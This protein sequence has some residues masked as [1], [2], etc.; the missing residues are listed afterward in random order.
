[1]SVPISGSLYM[2]TTTNV[3]RAPDQAGVYALYDVIYYS[4]AQGRSTTCSR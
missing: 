3:D 4:R 1:M 2:F